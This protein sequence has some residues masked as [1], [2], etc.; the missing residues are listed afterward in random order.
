MWTAGA[1]PPPLRRRT[2][3]WPRQAGLSTALFAPSTHARSETQMHEDS[4]L[5][6]CLAKPGATRDET[7]K[8]HH[9]EV[10]VEDQ[11]FAI[12]GREV[13]TVSLKCGRDGE[14]SQVWRDTYPDD[15]IIAPYL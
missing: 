1:L 7:P 5:E 2:V 4:L 15:V 8:G 13:G 6:Y 12:F 10:K 9:A 11:A 14:E 3:G